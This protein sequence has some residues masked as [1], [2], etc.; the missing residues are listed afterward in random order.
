MRLPQFG[1]PY[2]LLII[3][4]C[5]GRLAQPPITGRLEKRGGMFLAPEIRSRQGRA[6]LASAGVSWGGYSDFA[7]AVLLSNP[8]HDR[9]H[10][11]QTPASP[12]RVPQLEHPGSNREDSPLYPRSAAFC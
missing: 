11:M 4:E 9:L 10:P 5:D 12:I 3:G 8:R 2:Y 1:K 6:I 7:G